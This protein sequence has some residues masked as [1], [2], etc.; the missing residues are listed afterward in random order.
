MAINLKELKPHKISRDLT[1]YITYIYGKNGTGKTTMGAQFPKPL[2]LAFERGY[3]ALPGVYAQDVNSWS[4]MKQILRQLDDPDVKGMFQTVVIDTVD[5]AS[6]ACEK[7]LCN[8]LGIENIGDGGY[9]VNGWVKVKREWERTFTDL[10]KKGYAVLFISHAK[11]KSFTR[12]DGSTYDMIIPSCPSTYNEIIT[13]MVDIEGYID[14]KDGQRSLI[15]RSIDGTIE[16]KSR[17]KY[18]EAS[19]PFSYNNLVEAMNAAIDKE[20]ELNGSEFITT[21]RAA[22]REETTYDYNELMEEFKRITT[23]LLQKDAQKYAPH[24][25]AIIEKYLGKGKKVSETNPDQAD[26]IF[27]INDEIKRE[28]LKE[29]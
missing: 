12:A 4:E 27:L 19:I 15:F 6:A 20:G 24:L 28:V 25:T 9:K 1:G 18:I 8:Q 5:I 11:I 16:C 14:I 13:N 21:E 10:A 2:I 3:N 17:L 23:P 26:F 7:Y 29:A 22:L